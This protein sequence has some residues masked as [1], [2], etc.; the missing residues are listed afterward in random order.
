MAN[1]ALALGPLEACHASP[2]G[3]VSTKLFHLFFLGSVVEQ[4]LTSWHPVLHLT[5][6]YLVMLTSPCPNVSFMPWAPT[7][8]L[9]YESPLAHAAFRVE[10]ICKTLLEDP[11]AAAPRPMG[12]VPLE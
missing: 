7:L 2:P 10:L 1:L 4:R 9:G 3:L 11:I 12:M 8:L 5:G 6:A